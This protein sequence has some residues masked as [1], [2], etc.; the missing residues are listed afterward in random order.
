[1]KAIVQRKETENLGEEANHKVNFDS[2]TR[3][4]GKFDND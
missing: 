3:K 1:M 4:E 2:S